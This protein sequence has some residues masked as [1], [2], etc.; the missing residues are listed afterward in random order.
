MLKF[1]LIAITMFT[2]QN[3]S[4]DGALL[5]TDNPPS[6]QARALRMAQALS[7]KVNLEEG[8]YVKVKQLNERMLAEVEAIE[9]DY[10]ADQA[11]LDRHLADAQ[12]RYEASL[13]DL[14]RPTQLGAYQQVRRS[15]TALVGSAN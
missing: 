12:A 2:L 10:A 9:K 1:C 15:M 7:A 4:G 6:V 11:S 14:L 3:A 8:Q 5:F 13:L